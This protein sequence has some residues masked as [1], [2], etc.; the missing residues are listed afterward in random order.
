MR[1]DAEIV[2]A[3]FNTHT[4]V[5][6]PLHEY[7][8]L[9]AKLK[10]RS[11][12][13]DRYKRKLQE[14]FPLWHKAQRQK[15]DNMSVAAL[16]KRIYFSVSAIERYESGRDTPAD[17]AYYIGEMERVQY[18]FFISELENKMKRG[19]VNGTEK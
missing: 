5:A 3:R 10:E 9:R 14:I 11:K 12:Q 2:Y 19:G 17:M 16:S 13:A 7:D 18:E 8:G 1:A 6:I 4:H 15:M